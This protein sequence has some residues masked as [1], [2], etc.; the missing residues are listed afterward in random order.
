MSTK[1]DFYPCLKC[2]K[3]VLTDA[4]EC[5]LCKKWLHR[6]CAMLSKNEL[7]IIDEQDKIWLCFLCECTMPFSDIDDEECLFINDNIDV[8]KNL[9]ELYKQCRK[10]K[11]D[12]FQF[13]NYNVCDFE[14]SIDPEN[15]FLIH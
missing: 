5:C 12:A 9:Y 6:T 7:R 10:M 13:I 11:Y 15:N 14:N 4:V 3:N 8:D 2:Q 1:N